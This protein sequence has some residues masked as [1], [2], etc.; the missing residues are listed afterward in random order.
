[1][2]VKKLNIKKVVIAIVL[3]LIVILVIVFGFKKYIDDKKEKETFEYKF[4]QIGYSSD[5]ITVFKNQLTETQLETLLN[6]EYNSLYVD[7]VKQE[8]FDFDKLN[9]Y[10]EYSN[11]NSS[12][13]TD[14]LIA[15]VNVGANKN[16]YDDVEVTDVSKGNLMIV[17]KF[18]GLPSD[19]EPELILVSSTYAYANKY[20]SVDIYDDLVG[21]L[22]AARD[23]GFT[24][25]VSQGYRSY[26]DQEETYNNYKSSY[27]TSEA[28][29]FVARPGHSEYQ[30]GLGVDIEPYN[31]KVE[32]VTQSPEH[33][34]LTDNAYK[35]GF[36]LRYEEGKEDI[37]GFEAND[38]RFRYVGRNAALQ[39][40][41]KDL[42]FD[43]Y[44]QYYVK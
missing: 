13:S 18:Y 42:T 29:E 7:L 6:E 2:T 12:A 21:M 28:D 15:V 4:G 39:M 25:V 3:I 37:T 5:E 38:W 19:Y 32:D 22:E 10:I 8:Y 44:Y 14:K 40:H 1:M 17:N 26:A 34:W 43:E 36:I 31:K 35:Y 9:Q 30:T 33:K 41:D 24:L 23:D 11:N 16:W 20:V 27:S